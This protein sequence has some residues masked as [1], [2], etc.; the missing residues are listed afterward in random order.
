VVS[1]VHGVAQHERANGA[2]VLTTSFFSEPARRFAHDLKGQ[3]SLKDFV[4]LQVWLRH[5][6]QPKRS[7]ARPLSGHSQGLR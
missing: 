5:A 6:L 1:I 3:M 2:V 7:P 4:D